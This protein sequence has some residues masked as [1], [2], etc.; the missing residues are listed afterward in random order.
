MHTRRL[1]ILLI[2]EDDLGDRALIQQAFQASGTPVDLRFA[3]N[4]EEFLDYVHQ[5]PPWEKAE[6]PDLILLD[7]NMPRMSG[8]EALREIKTDPKLKSIPVVVLTTSTSPDDIAEAYWN[9]ANTYIPKPDSLEKLADAVRILCEFWF[10][11]GR[12]PGRGER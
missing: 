12:V 10:K 7:L 5:R 3:T 8:R 6:P 1:P 4:G 9:G 11:I 2:A